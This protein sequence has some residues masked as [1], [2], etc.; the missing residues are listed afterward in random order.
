MDIF[1]CSNCPSFFGGF[2]QNFQIFE[3]HLEGSSPSL[4]KCQDKLNSLWG[5][6]LNSSA[7][8]VENFGEKS[9][10]L[11]TELIGGLLKNFFGN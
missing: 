4:R 3:P 9:L 6:V 7:G 1:R 8:L 11:S 2:F 10:A 5:V